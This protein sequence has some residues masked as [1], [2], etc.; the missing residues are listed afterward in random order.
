MG[1]FREGFGAWSW[2]LSGDY[3]LSLARQRICAWHWRWFSFIMQ[4]DPESRRSICCDPFYAKSSSDKT[5]WYSMPLGMKFA[6]YAAIPQ[7][8]RETPFESDLSLKVS[9][10][11]VTFLLM[12]SPV[13]SETVHSSSA[14]AFWDHFYC[15]LSW[16]MITDPI[17][18][19]YRVKAN[20]AYEILLCEIEGCANNSAALWLIG[21]PC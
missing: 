4:I 9:K 6:K 3:F 10:G 7:C 11:V 1:T 14:L 21:S 8:I 15:F 13:C 12:L 19:I 16:E 2:K 20:L 17:F 18:C 5:R